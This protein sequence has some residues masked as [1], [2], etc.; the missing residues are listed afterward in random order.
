MF[1]YWHIWNKHK[2]YHFLKDP[3][4]GC[5]VKLKVYHFLKDPSFGCYVCILFFLLYS[6]MVCG[7]VGILTFSSRLT[8]DAPEATCD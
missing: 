2:V 7:L 1:A 8:L 4:F 6:T 3:S 5:Y